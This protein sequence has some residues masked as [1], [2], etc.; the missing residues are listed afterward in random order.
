MAV[1]TED[2][3]PKLG[4]SD[5]LDERFGGSTDEVSIDRLG[6]GHSNLTFLVRRGFEAWVLRRP[7]RGDI[8][9]GTHEMHREFAVM[10]ALHDAGSV[11]PVPR[12]ID[13][14]RDESYIGAPFYLMSLVDGVVVRGTPPPHLDSSDQ[15]R[16]IGHE[17]VDKLADIHDV[18]WKAVGLESMARKPEAFLQRNVERMQQLYDA[19][20]HRELPA[21]DDVG[22]WLRANM[23]EQRE[24]TL[25]HGDYKLDNVML[26]PEGD[27]Q[28]VAVVDWEISTIGDPL[29]DLGWLLYFAPA[30]AGYPS[31]AE[32]AQ[33]YAARR[34]VTLDDLRFYAAM[35]G[36]KIAI[37]MEGSNLRFKQGNADDAM[38]AALD[39]GV[40]A[41]AMRSQQIISGEIPV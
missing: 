9:P 13:L 38:F 15:R 39:A 11:V 12:P 24:V 30:D 29:V 18:D 41:L 16:R 8:Q 19:I 32:M 22:D 36:W 2:L 23:P 34:D 10:K 3:V 21:V 25:T 26:S 4:V 5:F 33:R 31:I 37:I 1:T 20:R 35:A 40:P 27:A 7:P 28:I 17:L 6:E 14:C